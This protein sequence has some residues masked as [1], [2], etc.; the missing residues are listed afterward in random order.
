MALV[1]ASLAA[2]APGARPGRGAARRMTGEAG[3]CDAR[4]RV[5]RT[6]GGAA[7]SQALAL[8]ACRLL[9]TLVLLEVALE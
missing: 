3:R 2:A 4:S 6:L 1:T 5:A 7:R 8:P 9:G